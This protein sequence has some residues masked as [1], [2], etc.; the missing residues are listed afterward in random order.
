MGNRK[1]KNK[2]G[3]N[4]R[5]LVTQVVKANKEKGYIKCNIVHLTQ[6]QQ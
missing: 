5:Q 6:N 2:R 3:K 1:Q 4:P